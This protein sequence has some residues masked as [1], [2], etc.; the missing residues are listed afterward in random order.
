MQNLTLETGFTLTDTGRAALFAPNDYAPKIRAAYKQAASN[1]NSSVCAVLRGIMPDVENEEETCPE[2]GIEL[3]AEPDA[4][5][6]CGECDA[7]LI[8]WNAANAQEVSAADFAAPGSFAA[9]LADSARDDSP[10][11]A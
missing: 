8:A 7:R 10:A 2:C 4:F 5:S 11:F 1:G 3:D 6:D 9:R